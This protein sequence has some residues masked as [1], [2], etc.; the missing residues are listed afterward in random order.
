[1]SAVVVFWSDKAKKSYAEIIEYL[2]SRWTYKEINHFIFRTE[3][4]IDRIIADPYFFKPHKE[5]PNIRQAILHP[6]VVLIYEITPEENMVN[7]LVFWPTRQNPQ[8]LILKDGD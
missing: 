7:L 1:M 6:T 2:E 3:T 5:D 8:K 4:T